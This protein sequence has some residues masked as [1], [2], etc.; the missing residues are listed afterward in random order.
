[1]SYRPRA[2]RPPDRVHPEARPRSSLGFFTFDPFAPG[3]EWYD[4]YWLSD[5]P[6]QHLPTSAVRPVAVLPVPKPPS[7][8]HRLGRAF[9]PVGNRG[10]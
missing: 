7:L 5:E 6:R 1:M 9:M 2:P 8:F 4:A 10:R 3:P